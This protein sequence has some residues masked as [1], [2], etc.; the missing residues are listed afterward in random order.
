MR[1]GREVGHVEE[2][3]VVH[4]G[5]DS[6][7]RVTIIVDPVTKL[8]V[9]ELVTLGRYPKW[10]EDQLAYDGS[11]AEPM[12]DLTPRERDI[13]VRLIHSVLWPWNPYNRD[14]ADR[15]H[16]AQTAILRHTRAVADPSDVVTL[17]GIA[18]A[19]NPRRRDG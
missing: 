11:S 9:G 3:G 17:Q 16:D 7:S 12:R 8:S 14:T 19:V 13:L 1:I 4:S 15:R 6:V 18:D 10:A 5:E 2:I